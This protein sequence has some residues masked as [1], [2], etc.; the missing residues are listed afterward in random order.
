MS[1]EQEAQRVP[2]KEEIISMLKDQIDVRELQAKLAQ[3][4]ADI[5]VAKAKELEALSFIGRTTQGGGQTPPGNVHTITQQDLDNNPEL[6]DEGLKVGDQVIIPTEEEVKK[7]EVEE[8]EK[9]VKEETAKDKSKR[10]LKKV[11]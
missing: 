10:S 9:A 5:A 1:Q 6:V 7:A 8:A 2:T 11:D 4:N 3:L